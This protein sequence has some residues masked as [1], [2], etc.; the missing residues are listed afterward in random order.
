MTEEEEEVDAVET[1]A[2]AEKP[3]L[4][5][6]AA[7]EKSSLDGTTVSDAGEAAALTPEPPVAGSVGGEEPEEKTLG[8][9]PLPPLAAEW[10]GSGTAPADDEAAAA[11]TVAAAEEIEEKGE[12][13]EEEG[14]GEEEEQEEEEEEQE[15]GDKEEEK[16][17]EQQEEEEEQEADT[18]GGGGAVGAEDQRPPAV[19]P[20]ATTSPGGLETRRP[21]S[22]GEDGSVSVPE[23][24]SVGEEEE[25]EAPPAADDAEGVSGL[26]GEAVAAAAAAA[27]AASESKPALPAAHEVP[28]MRGAQRAGAMAEKAVDKHILI[29]VSFSPLGTNYSSGVWGHFWDT[30]GT[31][32]SPIV[33]LSQL[34][35][36]HSHCKRRFRSFGRINH[37]QKRLK[38]WNCCAGL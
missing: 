23:V 16:L 8:L 34:L 37:P 9:P 25:A 20:T 27:E 29:E 14:E 22:A 28:E 1:A 24:D 31:I 30:W 10:E 3:V 36:A 19:A 33:F 38:G 21:P 2:V 11:A 6:E 18:E 15:E 35:V 32:S 12:G 17:E 4:V 26:S 13:E 7:G 5:L